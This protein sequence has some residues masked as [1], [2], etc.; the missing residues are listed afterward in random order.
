MW[1]DLD[2]R[3][4]TEVDW[5]NG[6]IVRLAS[7]SGVDAPLNRRIV[8]LVH[9]AEREGAGSPRLGPDEL[10]KRVTERAGR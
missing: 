6:E 10:W 1:Q 9:A 2:R 3:R 5:L 4:P 7:A 8:E